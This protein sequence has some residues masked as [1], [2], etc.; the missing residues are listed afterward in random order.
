M[1]SSSAQT[2]NINLLGHQEDNAPISRI[3]NWAI[4]YGRY[5]M[6]TTEIVVL[7]AFI[8][9]FSLDRKLTDL[10]EEINQKKIIL[11]SNQKFEEEFKSIQKKLDTTKSILERISKPYEPLF[12][13][14]K[15]LPQD[16]YLTEF[17]ISEKKII[18]S[19]VAGTIKSF[20]D[21]SSLLSSSKEF[22]HIEVTNIKKNKLKGLE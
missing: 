4:T 12:T 17:S 15:I 19:G 16:V 14:Q 8:S 21:F 13:I 6:I 18:L 10:R 1:S 5:I 2:I 3:I 22:K 11:E 7:L 20:S 9:R